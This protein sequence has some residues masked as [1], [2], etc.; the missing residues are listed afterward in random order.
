MLLGIF[1]LNLKQN[2]QKIN[3]AATRE[4]YSGHY[5]RILWFLL[6]N[7]RR[8]ALTNKST[9]ST[10]LYVAKKYIAQG[11]SFKSLIFIQKLKQSE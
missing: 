8:H 2:C 3:H 11:T 1:H 9:N 6:L 5:M 10:Q 7:E 4:I